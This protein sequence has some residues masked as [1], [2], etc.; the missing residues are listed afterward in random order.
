MVDSI[1]IN[2]LIFRLDSL[3]NLVENQQISTTYYQSILD[4]QWALLQAQTAIFVGILIITLTLVSIIAWKIYFSKISKRILDIEKKFENLNQTVN[5]V[6]L[7]EDQLKLVN[8][9]VNRSL[10]EAA[11][12]LSW[13]VIWHIRYCDAIFDRQTIDPL[14]IRLDQLELDFNN[15]YNDQNQFQ[16]FLKFENIGGLK[17]ILR[18]LVNYKDD[19]ISRV[20]SMI[21]DKILNKK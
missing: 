8:A 15:L 13:K 7:I 12:N 16:Q 18:K 1:Y 21:L 17:D 2:E 3:E 20:P 10:Y 5:K 4:H 14:I 19:R 6:E 9:N 11:S